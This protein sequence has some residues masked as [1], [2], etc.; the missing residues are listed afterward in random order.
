[1]HDHRAL[2]LLDQDEVGKAMHDHR[3][4]ALLD[5]VR[6]YR[7]CWR[8]TRV[9]VREN[10]GICAH[11]PVNLRRSMNYRLDILAIKVHRRSLSLEE[12][13]SIGAIL[14]INNNK[15]ETAKLWGLRK[16]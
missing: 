4:L 7:K 11:R 6:E 8:E 13:P 12:R 16:A 1:M 5:H 3:A 9:T 14:K 15:D 10:I 2:A